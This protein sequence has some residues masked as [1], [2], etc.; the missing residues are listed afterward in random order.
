V[1]TPAPDDERPGRVTISVPAG[2]AAQRDPGIQA[3]VVLFLL[4]VAGFVMLALAWRGGARTPYVPLQLPWMV[5]GGMA[6]LA[7][8]G[9]ALGAWSIHLGRRDDAEHRA[10]VDDLVREA[11]VLAEDLR[12]GRKQLPRR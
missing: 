7:L 9:M 10:Q 2:V 12:S 11:A 1:T 8:L 3:I 5:S 6:G 4:A